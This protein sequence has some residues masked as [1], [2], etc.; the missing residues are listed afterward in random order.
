MA[1]EL[2]GPS[3]E[4]KGI[5]KIDSVDVY[6]VLKTVV[7]SA[8]KECEAFAVFVVTNGLAVETILLPSSITLL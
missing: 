3:P 2:P 1:I 4:A 8:G 6:G 7:I 5:E